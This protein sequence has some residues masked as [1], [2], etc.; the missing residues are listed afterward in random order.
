MSIDG[1]G[2]NK[3]RALVPYVA[4]PPPEHLDAQPAQTVET[5][6]RPA[7]VDFDPRATTPREIQKV[8]ESLYLEGVI[9]W[10]EHAQLSFQADMHPDYENTIGALTGESADPERPRDYI[11]IWQRR[12]AFE[13]R[14]SGP[15]SAQ[16]EQ[17][18][19]ILS[20]LRR[21]EHPTDILA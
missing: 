10:E 12:L 5:V 20:L 19:H 7:A 21:L 1:L 8:S 15:N 14:H 2:S 9:T 16:S 18:T 17:A 4:P 6:L 3:G 13:R 11:K